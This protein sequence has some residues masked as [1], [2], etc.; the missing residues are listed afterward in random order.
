LLGIFQFGRSA[1]VNYWA[2]AACANPARLLS[3]SFA[4]NRVFKADSGVETGFS[5]QLIRLLPV[6]RAD[7]AGRAEPAVNGLF[8]REC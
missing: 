6:G 3:P 7:R 1:S 8:N 5:G 4:Q 2:P